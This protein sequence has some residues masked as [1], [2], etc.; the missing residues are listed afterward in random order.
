MKL[1]QRTMLWGITFMIAGPPLVALLSAII[2]FAVIGLGNFR[3]P[4]DVSPDALVFYFI[5]VL[6]FVGFFYFY[7]YLAALMTGLIVGISRKWLGLWGSVILS[8]ALGYVSVWL[9]CAIADQSDLGFLAI[10]G[11]VGAMYLTQ[12]MV[13]KDAA[14]RG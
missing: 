5:L 13:K 6:T 12:R 3:I 4:D 9:C 10:S 7:G 8:A 11:A 2:L 14:Y 1:T